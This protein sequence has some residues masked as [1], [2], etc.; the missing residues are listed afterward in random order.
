MALAVVGAYPAAAVR[1]VALAGTVGRT[2]T[3]IG[4]AAAATG[5]VTLAVIWASSFAAII[6]TAHTGTGWLTF[7]HAVHALVQQAKAGALA[8]AA[9]A[10]GIAA[11]RVGA[12]L[13][14][15]KR[16]MT[17]P[18]T[19]VAVGVISDAHLFDD[20]QLLGLITFQR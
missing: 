20:F 2:P 12:L 3:D 8:F 7:A 19:G 17:L 10:V 11:S 18:V 15:Y 13:V 4:G 1:T 5:L 6:A 16:N 14:A 9:A